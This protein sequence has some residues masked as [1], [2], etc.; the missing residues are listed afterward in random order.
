MDNMS[1]GMI[2]YS[3]K[4]EYVYTH[5]FTLEV[6]RLLRQNTINFLDTKKFL[7]KDIKIYYTENK[8]TLDSI[9][10]VELIGP[11]EKLQSIVDEIQLK[12][13]TK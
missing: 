6:G 13:V 4:S 7:N 8:G 10:F 9:F 5:R 12:L 3:S 11:L 1:S 2:N